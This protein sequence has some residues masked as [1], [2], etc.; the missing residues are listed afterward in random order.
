MKLTID[1]PEEV[2]SCIGDEVAINNFIL[3]RLKECYVANKYKEIDA[4]N[5]LA[6]EVIRT[7]ADILLKIDI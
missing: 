1:I 2:A 4:A 3:A 7:D 5:Y 6:K